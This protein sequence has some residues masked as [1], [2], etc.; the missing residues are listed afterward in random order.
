MSV[1]GMKR[2]FE[3]MM[4]NSSQEKKAMKERSL[5]HSVFSMNHTLTSSRKYE[6]KKKYSVLNKSIILDKSAICPEPL[7]I[8]LSLF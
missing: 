3:V 4:N 7:S 1:C 8:S 6:S 5:V 2:V